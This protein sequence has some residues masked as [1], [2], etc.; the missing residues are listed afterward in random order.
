MLIVNVDLIF[1]QVLITI[2][3]GDLYK[4]YLLN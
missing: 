2:V 4:N 3:F 1:C